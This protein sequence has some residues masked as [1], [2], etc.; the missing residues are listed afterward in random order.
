MAHSKTTGTA[1]S[2]E[3]N[4]LLKQMRRTRAAVL[5]SYDDDLSIA[6]A[7]Y[8]DANGTFIPAKTEAEAEQLEYF[9]KQN[10]DGHTAHALAK[11]QTRAFLDNSELR[12]IKRY[13]R[14]AGLLHKAKAKAKAETMAQLTEAIAKAKADAEDLD[15]LL[16][17]SAQDILDA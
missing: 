15:F 17:A 16:K 10:A 7:I 13:W 9:F 4:Q 5:G 8:I 14:Q 11:E 6:E 1:I 12:Q 3:L 2:A